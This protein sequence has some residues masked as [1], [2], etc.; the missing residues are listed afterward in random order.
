MNSLEKRV[1]LLA[2]E[3]KERKAIFPIAGSL[4]ALTSNTSE[5]W[6]RDTG[7]SGQVFIRIK[8]ACNAANADGLSMTTLTPMVATD[9]NFTTRVTYVGY[10][11]EPQPGDKSVVLNLRILYYSSRTIYIKALAT[12]PSNGVFTVL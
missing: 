7:P 4:V 9:A 1:A 6:V 5:T 8:F 12:G 11:N 2:R 10:Y 3:N